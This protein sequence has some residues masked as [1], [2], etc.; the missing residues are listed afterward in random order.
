MSVEHWWNDTEREIEVKACPN[1][2]L[3]PSNLTWIAGIV[4]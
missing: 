1:D 2:I 3:S 4:C